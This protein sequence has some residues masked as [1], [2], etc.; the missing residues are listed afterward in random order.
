MT[1]EAPNWKI[2]QM[3]PIRTESSAAGL[4]EQI[5]RLVHI[6]TAGPPVWVP[7]V[8]TA[9]SENGRTFPA[10]VTLSRTD[11]GDDATFILILRNINDRLLAEEKI[12][13]LSK[14]TERLREEVRS[15]SKVEDII[16]TSVPLMKVLKDVDQVA[17]TDATVLI[18]GE[19]GTGKELFARAI[20]DNSL[21]SKGRLISVNCAAIPEG[22]MESEFF[23]HE[24]G[25]FTGATRKR[26]GRFAMADGG[27]T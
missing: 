23:G 6:D 27:T 14:E 10:E 4:G 11:A 8:L 2:V 9:V 5:D 20:H 7:D 26:E 18:I 22:L 24:K 12:H 13:A 21:R 25:A 16:A 3:E 1:I 19:T 17:T 15:L